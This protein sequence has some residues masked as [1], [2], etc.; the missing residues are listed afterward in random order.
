MSHDYTKMFDKPTEGGNVKPLENQPDPIGL[1]SFNRDNEVHTKVERFKQLKK[2]AQ[3]LIERRKE[4]EERQ[5]QK[6]VIEY[7]G[8]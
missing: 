1:S 4:Y 7:E 2:E 5:K 6:G 8:D 3:K